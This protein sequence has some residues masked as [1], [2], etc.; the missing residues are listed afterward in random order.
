[1]EK[2]ER[3]TFPHWNGHPFTY[4][5]GG[6][7][8]FAYTF[9]GAFDKA[10]NMVKWHYKPDVLKEHVHRIFPDKGEIDIYFKENLF[11]KSVLDAII[12]AHW[13]I[14][15]AVSYARQLNCDL[16]LAEKWEELASNIY[17]PQS[18]ENYLEYLDDDEKREGGGYFGIRAPMA[19]AFPYLELLPEVDRDKARKTLD[20]AWKRNNEGHGMITYVSN[21]FA[22]T[23]SYLGFKEQAFKMANFVLKNIDPSDA[24]ICEA[25]EYEDN[26][27][28][29][30]DWVPKFPYYLTNYSAFIC[31]TVSFLIQSCN[32]EIKVFPCVPE[33]W[34]NVEFYDL[35]AEGGFKILAK[36]TNGKTEWIEI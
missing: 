32:H 35:P 24:A 36:M 21:W 17:I 10:E 16:N 2:K 15:T 34:K 18:E 26:D 28:K 8:I 31:S 33:D 27:N 30:G 4:R 3:N 25:Y 5:Q 6:W 20:K 1:M 11:E 12:G 7:G 29:K 19:L 23:E 13:N 22:L 14:K 9:L